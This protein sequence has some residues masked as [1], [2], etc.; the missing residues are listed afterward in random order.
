M[1]STGLN[2]VVFTSDGEF[3]VEFQQFPRNSIHFQLMAGEMVGV[4]YGERKFS[5]VKK[6]T[7]RFNEAYS[8]DDEGRFLEMTFNAF[9][10][11]IFSFG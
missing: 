10:K 8:Y 2:S 11:G 5:F 4:L 6:C 9:K 1:L 7:D 3:T